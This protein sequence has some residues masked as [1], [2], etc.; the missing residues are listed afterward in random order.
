[1]KQRLCEE[2][3]DLSRIWYGFHEFERP[4]A[5]S[6]R[7]MAVKT[8]FPSAS[9]TKSRRFHMRPFSSDFPF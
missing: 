6:K 8:G 1:M 7:R 3:E 4:N 9:L 5:P 2:E